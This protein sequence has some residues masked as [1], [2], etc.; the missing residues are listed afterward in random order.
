MSNMTDFL[1]SG[2]LNAMLRGNPDS[3]SFPIGVY[4]GLTGDNPND[5]TPTANELSGDGYARVQ[6]VQ[7][8]TNW[9][10]VTAG[11]KTENGAA[12]EFPEASAT[13]D[14]ASGVVIMDTGTGG[15]CLLYGNLSTPRQAL[16]GDVLR[17][18]SGDLE[19]TF[20]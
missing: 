12:I 15:N 16:T 1:E 11:G 17:F 5:A 20:A 6:V 4:V 9:T 18:K 3:Y 8:T 14:T 19:I 7:N 2:L 10:A 13:W